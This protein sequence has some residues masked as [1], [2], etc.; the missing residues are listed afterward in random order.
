MD[1]SGNNGNSGDGGD[2]RNTRNLVYAEKMNDRIASM[3]KEF[4]AIKEI[5]KPYRVEANAQITGALPAGQTPIYQYTMGINRDKL[6][7][8]G[9]GM[10][11]MLAAVNGRSLEESQA[12]A[13]A[14]SLQSSARAN[15]VMKWAVYGLPVWRAYKNSRTIPPR[16]MTM[17][18]SMARFIWPP[19]LAVM[20]TLPV[21]LF[22]QPALMA[23]IAHYYSN[24]LQQD[25]RM[26]GLRFSPERPIQRGIPQQPQYNEFEQASSGNTGALS[27]QQTDTS[28]GTSWGDYTSNGDRASSYSAPQRSWGQDTQS[29][30]TSQAQQAHSGWDADDDASP[31]APSA[32][33]L[34]TA[35]GSSAWDRIRSQSISQQNQPAYQGR[36]FGQGSQSSG[37]SASD[38]YSFSPNQERSGAKDQ[39]QKEFDRLVDRDRQGLDQGK[40][41]WSK[42]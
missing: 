27:Q 13:V 15:A 31:I 26:R 41:A 17:M 9:E 34:S 24:K 33:G 3:S 10:I 23:S 12:Q 11:S 8:S 37:P 6:I 35:P 38:N 14:Q 39:A 2:G 18:G 20:Y 22:V 29:Q 5:S 4:K 1:D 7:A 25:P 30:S 19:A 21:V 36:Q 16:I 28:S 32:R 40:E 42:R